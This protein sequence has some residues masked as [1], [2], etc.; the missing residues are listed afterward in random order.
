VRP[1]LRGRRAARHLPAAIAALAGLLLVW[2]RLLPLGHS[3]WNDEAFSALYYIRPGPGAIFGR[4][5]P[6]DHMLFELLAWATANLTGDFSEPMLRAWSVLPAIAAASLMTAWLWRRLG[7][8]VAAAFAV[9]A[10]TAPQYMTLSSQARGYGLAYLAV[11]VMTIAADRLLW[12][13]GRRELVG[14]AAAA[15][16]GIWTLPVFALAVVPLAALLATRP[17]LRRSTAWAMAAVAIAALAF[18]A[19]VLG[20]VLHSSGQHFGVRLPWYGVVS[21]PLEDQLAPSVTLL[22]ASISSGLAAV[23]AGL[24]VA[25]GV[26]SLWRRPERYLALVLLAPA[27]FAYL[28]LEAARL[29]EAPRFVSF[30]GLPLLALP[31]VALAHAG[32]LAARARFGGPVVAAAAAAL[33]LFALDKGELAS[34][35][36][37]ATPIENFSLAARIVAASGIATVITNST[38]PTGFRYYLGAGRVGLESPEIL[39][40]LFCS[41]LA[42]FVYLEHGHGPQ[43]PTSCLSARG[44]TPVS[45]PQ[46]RSTV[47]VWLVTAI[48]RSGAGVTLPTVAPVLSAPARLPASIGCPGVVDPP[49]SGAGAPSPAGRTLRVTLRG[50]SPVAGGFSADLR[51]LGVRLAATVAGAFVAQGHTFHAPAGFLAVRYRITNRGAFMIKPAQTLAPLAGLEGVTSQTVQPAATFDADCSLLDTSYAVAHGLASPYV[52]LLPGQSATTVSVY[53]LPAALPSGRLTLVWSAAA[54]GLTT[55]LPRPSRGG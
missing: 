54:L 38:E 10:A 45:V 27:G 23:V 41:N 17:S 8:G 14:F 12:L 1:R 30:V 51:V 36:A 43:V 2:S 21:G 46:T 47:R 5:L 33:A 7:A 49:A 22:V 28:V 52:H 4:Y 50:A 34:G 6:N 18:Y 40:A 9:L 53:P 37:A 26:L 20:D 13:G 39:G 24:L 15:I 29:Y 55:A 44:A 35:R 16:A 25:A 32:R 11:V 31:A 48:A 3:L 42:P 19:P